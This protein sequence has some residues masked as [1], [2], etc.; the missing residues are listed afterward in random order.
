MA[1]HNVAASDVYYRACG[2]QL[3]D[4]RRHHQGPDGER[5]SDRVDRSAFAGW[6]SGEL[7]V[8]SRTMRWCAWRTWRPSS[9]GAENYDFSVAFNGQRS[10]FIGIQTA[11]AANVLDVVQA[12]VEGAA[13]HRRA[14]AGGHAR[15]SWS[16]TRPCSST[17]RS[18]EVIKTLVEALI[19]VT[20]VIFLFLGSPRAVL[21]AGGGHAAVAGGRILPDAGAGLLDQSADA[22]GAGAGDRAGGGRCHHRRR[23]RR[24]S[25]EGGHVALS[26]PLFRR[27]ASSA[28]RSSP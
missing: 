4:R 20:V 11:P 13:G 3:P 16:T 9:L 22:A 10:V 1:A 17:P 26:R 6:S 7:I 25:S 23:E 8:A 2:Q 28:V 19:I 15:R 27:R 21:D 5:R 14:A 12:C 18:R 24:P